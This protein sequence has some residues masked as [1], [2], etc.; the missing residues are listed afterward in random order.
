[1]KNSYFT[2]PYYDTEDF[3]IRDIFP[4]KK[5]KKLTNKTLEDYAHFWYY[6]NIQ[7][8]TRLELLSQT[9]YSSSMYWDIL[10]L[11]NQMDN[12]W[13]LPKS[14]DYINTLVDNRIEDFKLLFT[15]ER[16]QETLALR[17]AELYQQ[18]FNDNE[19]HRRFRFINK[20]H[21]PNLTEL[22]KAGAL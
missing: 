6:K 16:M 4:T 3:Q 14:E 5:N 17:K 20:E 12:I 18:Y 7:D 8:N 21:I 1:M 13:D 9:E 19:K 10:F 2:L 11:I 22:M 15:E